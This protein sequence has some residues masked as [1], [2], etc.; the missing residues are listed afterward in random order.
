MRIN[1]IRTFSSSYFHLV[2]L[3]KIYSLSWHIRLSN[4]MTSGAYSILVTNPTFLFKTRPKDCHVHQHRTA[5]TAV[6]GMQIDGH[7]KLSYNGYCIH[8]VLTWLPRRYWHC[9]LLLK[10]K[11]LCFAIKRKIVDYTKNQIKMQIVEI[12]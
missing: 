12:D 2:W 5:C 1:D 7:A 10:E 4:F 9:D 11:L 3:G 6:P 8:G